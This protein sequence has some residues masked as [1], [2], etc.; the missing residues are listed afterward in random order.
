MVDTAPFR[1][2]WIISDGLAVVVQDGQC[3]FGLDGPVAAPAVGTRSSC[4]DNPTIKAGCPYGVIDKSGAFRVTPKF[5]YIRDYAQGYAAFKDHG[6]WGY[7]DK[8]G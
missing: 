1:H 2:G 3:N 7:L 8:I 6:L 5:E 4:G